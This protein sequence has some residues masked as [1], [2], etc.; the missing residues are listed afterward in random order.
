MAVDLARLIHANTGQMSYHTELGSLSFGFVAGAVGSLSIA[1]N[2]QG[3]R[4]LQIRQPASQVLPRVV[5]PLDDDGLWV[6]EV[7]DTLGDLR[8]FIEARGARSG[9][10]PA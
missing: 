1:V 6:A 7:M 4:R 8:R 9:G 2:W 10:P 3:L 5:E